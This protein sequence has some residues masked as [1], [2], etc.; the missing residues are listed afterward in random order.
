MQQPSSAQDLLTDA[1]QLILLLVI[2]VGDHI[3]LRHTRLLNQNE[4]A[5]AVD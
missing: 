3:L 2:N 1:G 5:R 4:R